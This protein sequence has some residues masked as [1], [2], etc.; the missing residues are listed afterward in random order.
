MR[1]SANALLLTILLFALSL[2]L[3]ATKWTVDDVLLQQSASAFEIS[4][5]G[6]LVVWVQSRMNKKKGTSVS[7]LHLRNLAAGFAVQLTRGTESARA[8]KFSPDATR[9]AFL[10]SRKAA[11]AKPG[12]DK[13]SK[14]AQVWILDVRGGEPYQLT[15]FKKGVKAAA[16]LDNE[17][18]LVTATE[19]PS[20]YEQRNKEHK[21]TSHVVDDDAH[22]PPVRLFRVALKGKQVTRLT[23]NKDRIDKTYVSDD[24]A[25]AVTI[26]Q[27]SLAYEYNQNI[28]PVTFLHDLKNGTETQLFP[29]GKILPRNVQ[30][31]ADSKGF[32]FSTPFTHDPKY[33]FGAD[34]VL[35]YYD[36]GARQVARV[37]LDWDRHLGRTFTV[38]PHG[39]LALL[40]DGVRYKPALFE[41]KGDTWTRSWVEGKHAAN[42]FNITMSRDG[43]TIV[44]DH[45]T[46]ST[47]T[48]LYAASLAGRTIVDASPSPSSTP[49]STPKSRRKPRSSTGRA[50]TTTR[51]KASF[52]TRTTTW[53]GRNTRSCS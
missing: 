43:K 49:T 4:H 7:H 28:R 29:D 32:Y 20:L 8:P 19:D 2:P 47:P 51:L 14:V 11:D 12:G 21:D 17:T 52:T 42:I 33:D 26:H 40:A 31:T 23:T 13:S 10:S 53:R 50:P 48:Q 30:F 15:S 5:D 24:G 39:V 16:W 37:D 34:S 18:L 22:A 41:K 6:Q 1:S 38:T 9:I 44:Y 45:S 36:L 27:R 35:Y 3:A 46:A 25:W